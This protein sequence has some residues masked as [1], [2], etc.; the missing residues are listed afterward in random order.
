MSITDP[1]LAWCFDEACVE[2][3]QACQEAMDDA[4]KDKS[5][6]SAKGKS[7]GL[8]DKQKDARAENALRKMLG[9]KQK[10]RGIE[11]ARQG[12]VRS[13]ADEDYEFDA[14]R[15]PEEVNG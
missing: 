9:L 12:R 2:F 8:S 14:E 15:V 13:T 5:K 1:Y 6:S 3:G 4:R 10:F 11:S 7:K